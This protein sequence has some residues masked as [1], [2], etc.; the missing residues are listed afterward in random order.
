[1]PLTLRGHVFLHWCA[2]S[3]IKWTISTAVKV[4]WSC[5][6]FE[7]LIEETLLVVPTRGYINVGAAHHSHMQ[8]EPTFWRNTVAAKGYLERSRI[9]APEDRSWSRRLH[10]EWFLQ[11]G[12]HSP[13][14]KC[15]VSAATSHSCGLLL[16]TFETWGHM[17]GAYS[18]CRLLYS[19]NRLLDVGAFAGYR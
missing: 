18:Q 4:S 5:A 9:R 7:A 2:C 17:H 6:S 12:M 16:L 15:K 8:T 13:V 11:E 1:M 10:W 3:P 14:V 19:S